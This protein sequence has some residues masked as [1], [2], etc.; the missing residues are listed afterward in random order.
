[1]YMW[2]VFRRIE[3]LRRGLAYKCDERTDEQ[4]DRQVS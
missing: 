1:M 3:P 4:T 2:K